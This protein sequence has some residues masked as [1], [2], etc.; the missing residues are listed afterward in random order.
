MK[1]TS[2]CIASGR[3]NVHWRGWSVFLYATASYPVKGYEWMWSCQQQNVSKP[4]VSILTHTFKGTDLCNLTHSSVHQQMRQY[5]PVVLFTSQQHTQVS[6]IWLSC[7][8]SF[9]N[10]FHLITVL[11]SSQHHNAVWITRYVKLQ[12]QTCITS[13]LH[14][15]AF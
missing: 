10:S 5:L 9:N 13:S 7:S 4:Y 6:N 12:R 1:A 15:K 2:L 11:I 14:H 3:T 8:Q